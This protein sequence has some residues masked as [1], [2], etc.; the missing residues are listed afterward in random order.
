M[1]LIILG[2][3]LILAVFVGISIAVAS[4]IGWKAMLG[5]WAFSIAVT[6]VITAAAFLISAGAERL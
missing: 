4:Q 3:A 1:T 5:G 2:G 6:A